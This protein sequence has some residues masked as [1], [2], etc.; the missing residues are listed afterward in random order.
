VRAPSA[1]ALQKELRTMRA[2]VRRLQRE[3]A[4]LRRQAGATG[5]TG[6]TGARGPVGA[7]GATGPQGEKGEKGEKGD[8]ATDQDLG[9]YAQMASA[10][11]SIRGDGLAE[12]A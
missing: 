5:A 7:T 8:L 2:Q 3:M 12:D 9:G 11:Q 10:Q 6:A 1:A 4:A